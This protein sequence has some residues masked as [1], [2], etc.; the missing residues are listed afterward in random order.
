MF[1]SLAIGKPS[2]DSGGRAEK[3]ERVW[4]NWEGDPFHWSPEI[5]ALRGRGR[6]GGQGRGRGGE[7]EVEVEVEVAEVAAEITALRESSDLGV[8]PSGPASAFSQPPGRSGPLPDPT[9]TSTPSRAHRLCMPPCRSMSCRSWLP[10]YGWPF[11]RTAVLK[12]PF[13]RVAVL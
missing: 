5:T 13:Y 9:S 8:F 7:V 11:Y 1:P 2:D 10:F 3:V 12:L 4:A 6:G